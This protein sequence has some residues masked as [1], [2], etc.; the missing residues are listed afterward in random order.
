LNHPDKGP[1]RVL[2]SEPNGFFDE[3]DAN[4]ATSY[5]LLMEKP[6]VKQ[7]KSGILQGLAE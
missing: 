6:N 4:K 1:P 2:N 7:K 3:N 5:S